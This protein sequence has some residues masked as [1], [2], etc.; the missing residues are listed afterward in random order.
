VQ[1]AF[2]TDSATRKE[3]YFEAEKILCVDEAGI[4]PIYYY[5]RVVL[6]RPYVERGYA[7]FA[8]QHIDK[9]KVH[10]H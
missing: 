5:T 6:T 8:G 10:A 1:A 3:L 4:I 2:E 7:S 9:W